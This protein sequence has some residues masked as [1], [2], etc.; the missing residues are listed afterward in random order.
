MEN[1]LSA[2]LR[3]F[4]LYLTGGIIS[5]I[6]YDIFK[7]KRKLKSCNSVTIF[8]QDIL[9]WVINFILATYLIVK[10]ETGIRGYGVFSFL[11]GFVLY[12]LTLSRLVVFVSV[13][14][15]KFIEKLFVFVLKILF[16]PLFLIMKILN[17]PILVIKLKFFKK[18]TKIQLT[19][20]NFCF[21]IKRKMGIVI[22]F[23]KKG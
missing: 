9:F 3:T 20:Y 13:A 23:L 7:V 16:F 21:K 4:F 19:L 8:I 2:E 14:V 18:I 22:K 6:T 10:S 15:V 12:M 17:K 1:Y 11:L 5:G